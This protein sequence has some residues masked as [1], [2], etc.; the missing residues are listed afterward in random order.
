MKNSFYPFSYPLPSPFPISMSFLVRTGLLRSSV[1]K[2]TRAFTTY[3]PTINFGKQ[4]DA[5]IFPEQGKP[6]KSSVWICSILWIYFQHLIFH[7][8]ILFLWTRWFFFM[9]L[10]IVVYICPLISVH[11]NRLLH[12]SLRKHSCYKIQKHSFLHS[13]WYSFL[14]HFIKLSTRS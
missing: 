9:E 12:A 13:Y 3:V 8:S 14:N 1:T 7:F 11:N 5:D 4:Y 6:H 10:E 2:S